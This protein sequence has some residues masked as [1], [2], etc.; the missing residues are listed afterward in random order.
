MGETYLKVGFSF[1]FLVRV[2]AKILGKKYLFNRLTMGRLYSEN[3]E[4]SL[5]L[6]K[7]KNPSTLFRGIQ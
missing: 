7:E 1:L 4:D 3:E 2:I 5:F 6:L